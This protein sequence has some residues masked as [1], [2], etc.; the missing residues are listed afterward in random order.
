MSKTV[1]SFDLSEDSI[2]Q[3]IQK[4]NQYERDIQK[5][6]DLLRQKVADFLA[7]EAQSG[8]NGAIVD[9]IIPQSGGA[10]VADV[11]VEVTEGGYKTTLV[12]ASGSDATWIEFGAGVY[13]NG[14]V[15]SSPN[16]YGV[17]LGYTIG[18]YGKGYGSRKTWA[19]YDDD[20]V[21]RLTHGTE[22][23]MPMARAVTDL[24][25]EYPRIAKEVFG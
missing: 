17:K 25:N 18:G 22:A 13:H 23:K 16:P 9:D 1:I 21:K 15:G 6:E 12:I 4:L 24:I 2:E 19:F 11:K 3:A 8:F 20:D 10:K 5:K 7:D 14:A